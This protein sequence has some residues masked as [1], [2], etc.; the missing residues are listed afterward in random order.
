LKACSLH[1]LARRIALA[2]D[3]ASRQLSCQRH[4]SPNQASRRRATISLAEEKKT[5]KMFSRV[6]ARSKIAIG[7]QSG[8]IVW[9]RDIAR[10]WRIAVMLQG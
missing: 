4:L 1:V 5:K 2:R 6:D 7:E 8:D 10:G 3:N 9:R